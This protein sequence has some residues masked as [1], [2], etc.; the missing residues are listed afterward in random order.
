MLLLVS[1]VPFSSFSAE[2]RQESYFLKESTDTTAVR[3]AN[4]GLTASSSP[5][6]M[7]AVSPAGH[8]GALNTQGA[9]QGIAIHNASASDAEYLLVPLNLSPTSALSL[10]IGLQGNIAAA[11]GNAGNATVPADDPRIVR[12]R[13]MQ[14]DF[15]NR[16]GG[17]DPGTPLNPATAV[18]HGQLPAVGDTWRLNNELAN[19]CAAGLSA[20]ADVIWVGDNIIVLT[21]KSNPAA[22]W[23]NTDLQNALTAIDTQVYPAVTSKFGPPSDLDG[24]GKV[25]IFITQGFNRLD[26][27]ASSSGVGLYLPRDKLSR[28]EC[29]TGNVGE[30]VYMLAPDPTGVVNSN[31][32]TVSYVTGALAPS[33]ARELAHMVMDGHRMASLSPFEETWLDEALGGMAMEQAFYATSVG[34][35]PFSNILLSNLTTGPNASRRVAAF[36]TYQNNLYSGWR[37]WLQFPS[38]MGV[39]DS[40]R[41][42]TASSGVQWAFLRYVTDR[43]AGISQANET[44]FLQSLVNSNLTGV[45]NIRQAI[46]AEPAQWL[47]DFLLSVYLDDNP[48][49]GTLG[50][51]GIYSMSS[52]N[53]RSVYG[54][55]GG[56]PLR[57]IALP[58][59][60]N[61]S[62]LLNRQ[63]SSSYYRFAVAANATAK[64]S[65]APTAGGPSGSYAIIPLGTS[66]VLDIPGPLTGLSATPAAQSARVQWTVAPGDGNGSPSQF[67]AIAQFQGSAVGS[68][69]PVGNA[70]ECTIT[71][72][73]DGTTYAIVMEATN[74]A[75]NGASYSNGTTVTP[76]ETRAAQTIAFA[77]PGPQQVGQPLALT[78]STTSGLQVA[79]TVSPGCGIQGNTVTFATAGTA[80][81]TVTATQAGDAQWQA[82]APVSHA[83]NAAKGLN[84]I[85]FNPQ[86][87]QPYVK[88]G[89]FTL[90]PAASAS[91]GLPV[92]YSSSTP[93]VCSVAGATVGIIGAGTCTLAA[94][95]AGD[96][97]WLAA[98]EQTRSVQIIAGLPDAPTGVT[99]E[100]GDGRATVRWTAPVNTGGVAIG[101]YTV[102]AQ[103]DGSK[104]CSAT[105][106]LTCTVHGLTGG[107]AYTFTV[108]ATNAAGK[109][110]A[111]SQPSNAVTPLRR[112]HNDSALQAALT[113][114]GPGCT[115]ESSQASPAG[116]VTDLPSQVKAAGPQFAFKLTGCDV[117]GAVQMQIDYTA[118]LPASAAPLQYWKKNSAGQWA[119]YAGAQ[120][121]GNRVT[122]TLTD[123]GAGD[124]D[125]IENGEIVDPGVVVQ[126][127]G[128]VTAVPVPLTGPWL[129]GLLSLLV[130]GSGAWRVRRRSA[131]LS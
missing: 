93:Q 117:R 37:S 44:S 122:L 41:I 72:L 111:A 19:Q 108:V 32:R 17:T 8:Q 92:S 113:G 10:E 55:L 58:A 89:S 74:A 25:V 67:T 46:N 42:N 65:L 80:V 105:T 102:A 121:T 11:A 15:L 100:P 109:A 86:A 88:D 9:I 59:N 64:L 119:V 129:L 49:V 79:F 57:D 5:M 50:S 18:P 54:G 33:F 128:P 124:A 70:N 104:T 81:C 63:G 123:G 4:S 82:A 34:L 76:Q 94:H 68:C 62:V 118:S 106:G 95:Q 69:N 38:S 103:A 30:V 51:T 53:F 116:A 6:A 35:G 71:G 1:L 52:W 22:T 7:D 36:N 56:F 45:D 127:A 99:A 13:A 14:A 66:A 114:G 40:N 112:S 115:F 78:A 29:A 23:N 20:E 125:G 87:S 2:P 83:L 12:R 31:V 131:K 24:N 98:T 3:A 43:Y 47:R 75:G 28:Q 107:T 97:N 110:S 85:A 84:T 120:I 77:D 26:A 39:M 48:K 91:S 61:A 27:A 90:Q 60:G 96:V 130:T 126:M 16:R 21:D 101:S 73:T